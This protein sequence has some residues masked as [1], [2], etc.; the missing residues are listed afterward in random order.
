M[1]LIEKRDMKEV[2]KQVIYNC[3]ENENALFSGYNIWKKP[4]IC[5][6]KTDNIEIAQLKIIVSK[7]HLLPQD[8]LVDAKSIISFFLGFNSEIVKS[9]IG[10]RLASKEWAF[11]YLRTNNLITKINNKIAEVMNKYGYKA[12]KIPATNN[13]NENTL[14]SNWSHRHIAYISG[15]G[16]FG[17]NN[18]LIT[19]E[20]CCGRLGSVVTNFQ[21]EISPKQ[22]NEKCLY[23][24]NKSCGLC[25]SK[26]VNDVYSTSGFN[27]FKCYQM[28][29]EN[30]AY[31]KNIG[32]ADV[33]GKCLVGL[34]CSSRDPSRK[35]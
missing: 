7:D 16:T 10:G 21:F 30:A 22:I 9:N 35:K 26:C 4:L 34:P 14:L 23:K 8:I 20:G 19:E 18:M 12:G 11:T 25:I 17:I 32:N 13:F 33:C 1:P 24:I 2:V 15:L 6:L 27:R 31:Y 3:V 28:C 5:F 29:L